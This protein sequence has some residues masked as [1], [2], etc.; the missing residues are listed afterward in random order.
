MSK[1]N[2]TNSRIKL[3]KKA[4]KKLDPSLIRLLSMTDEVT[5]RKFKTE[6]AKIK[7]KIKEIESIAE[8]LSPTATI[9]DRK[10]VQ[11]VQEFY[12]TRLYRPPIF[13]A[14]IIDE[15]KIEPIKVRAIIH[16]TGNRDDLTAMGLKVIA[17]AQDIFTIIGTKQQLANLAQQP[18]TL[19]ISLPVM[20]VTA[21]KDAAIQA[22]IYPV[23]L[24]NY[25]PGVPDGYQGDDVIVGIIDK[26]IDVT[27]NAFRHPTGNH[28][29]RILYYWVQED[30]LNNPNAPG[31]DPEEYMN[32]QKN[33]NLDAPD[34]SNL[35]K[36][37]VY[38]ESAINT[39][40]NNQLTKGTYGNDADQICCSPL[41]NNPE[42]H[43]TKVAGIAVGNGYDSSW[44][45]GDFIGAAPRADIVFVT[46]V[47]SDFNV[48]SALEFILAVTQK[49]NKSVVVNM[50]FD[51]HVGPHMG[52]DNI[53][54]FIDNKLNPFPEKKKAI[55]G[56]T[57]NWNLEDGF[58]KGT[59]IGGATETFTVSPKSDGITIILDIWYTGPELKFQI[60]IAGDPSGFKNTGSYDFNLSGY[61]LEVDCKEETEIN[62]RQLKITVN[63]VK[64][65]DPIQIE[66]KN[67]SNP[68]VT[69]HAWS[70]PDARDIEISNSTKNEMTLSSRACCKSQI[71]VGACAKNPSGSFGISDPD[72]TKA[73]PIAYYS[74]AGPTV[75]G[76]IK[77][78]IVTV[79]GVANP[80]YAETFNPLR[81][82]ESNK[83]SSYNVGVEGTSFAAP[84]V[85]GAVAL[86]FQA[87]K[88]YNYELNHD[89]VK[90]LLIQYAKRDSSDDLN[91]YGNGRLRL[92]PAIDHIK[93]PTPVDLWIRTADDDYG[94]EPFLGGCI[95]AS[96]DIKVYKE[97]TNEEI[98]ELSWDKT[99]DV[100]VVVHN[101]GTDLAKD[102][103]ISLKYT[104]PRATP[105]DWEPCANAIT[106]DVPA[107]D[108]IEVNFKWT[109]NAE[110]IHAEPGMT[111]FCLLA[112]AHHDDDSYEYDT[113]DP[114]RNNI[115]GN[116][117]IALRNVCIK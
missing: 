34:F 61:N 17:Q 88:F 22:D 65:S 110:K 57:Q 4:A 68:Q 101:L 30:M 39:A 31:L 58:R 52:T 15:V 59:I 64:K 48:M 102:A 56:C 19:S 25:N 82:T 10:A 44:N 86:L 20:Y 84:L 49:E 105:V 91:S 90:A 72:P 75:D 117:N 8:V 55:V 46:C 45:Q 53:D 115:G 69:Y 12:K 29:T 7:T 60:S 108:K 9:E 73:E 50:S 70:R 13:D 6:E 51:G 83:N 78:E 109:P 28:N 40:L 41:V 95:C 74:G 113:D 62:M 23:H 92:R 18:A 99:Y 2:Q 27:H 79:G 76:R 11:K 43:G 96:P 32:Q 21:M 114:W 85:T 106:D 24:P 104:K 42:D 35:N 89:T 100:K 47:T 103:T 16:F 63:N 54:K 93:G 81:T 94:L 66:L 116:N 26:P 14:I 107:L 97:G 112:E 37:R 1:R 87:A 38:T 77:P 36:G 98:Y 71:S 111:H 3:T 5:L 33:N 67:P 80:N